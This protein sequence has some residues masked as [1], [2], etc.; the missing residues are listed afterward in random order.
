MLKIL[1]YAGCPSLSLAISAA[2]FTLKMRVE[3]QNFQKTL[4]SHIV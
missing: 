4:K 3:A 2:K 1:A